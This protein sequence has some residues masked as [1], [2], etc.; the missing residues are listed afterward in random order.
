MQPLTFLID[1]CCIRLLEN[2]LFVFLQ[3]LEK[4]QKKFKSKKSGAQRDTSA[5]YEYQVHVKGIATKY[6]TFD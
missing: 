3:D 5:C 2:C 4:T 6:Y 1:F